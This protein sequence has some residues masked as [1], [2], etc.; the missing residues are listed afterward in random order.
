MDSSG[1]NIKKLTG[2]TEYQDWNPVWLPDGQHIVFSRRAYNKKTLKDNGPGELY[3]INVESG[4]A[5]SIT[6]TSDDELLA[7]P[8]PTGKE[9]I[10]VV[11]T[12]ENGTQISKYYTASWDGEVLG[13]LSPFPYTAHVP[14][15]RPS[16]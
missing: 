15:W 13:R 9:F 16:P 1:K 4:L 10:I 5:R 14:A 7:L 6:F 12:E 8:S 3:I 11:H 2:S